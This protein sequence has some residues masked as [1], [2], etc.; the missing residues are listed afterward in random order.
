[1]A[2][3]MADLLHISWPHLPD[4][5]DGEAPILCSRA[6]DDAPLVFLVLAA[7]VFLLLQVQRGS[8]SCTC[9]GKHRLFCFASTDQTVHILPIF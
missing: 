1:M 6:R 3:D 5:C 2:S 7:A 8:S 9:K 4:Q